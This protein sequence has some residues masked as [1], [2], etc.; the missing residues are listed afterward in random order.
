ML[1]KDKVEFGSSWIY[2]LIFAF[3]LIVYSVLI[4]TPYAFLDSYVS[5][6]EGIRHK[7]GTSELFHQI[8]L[9]GRLLYA[10]F[11]GVAFNI[12]GEIKALAYLRALAVIGIG[13]I[14]ALV[15]RSLSSTSIPHPVA[16]V[17]ALLFGLM[18]SYQVYA[19]WAVCF[20]FPWAS[21]LAA[22][23]FNYCDE[24]DNGR[25]R[26]AH[27]CASIL[28]LSASMEIYQP[29]AM[30]F[31]VFAAIAWLLR[32]NLPT[33]RSIFTAGG[34]MALS[35][36]LNYVL[37]KLVPLV[38][39]GSAN[40]YERAALVHNYSEK[41][42]WFLREPLANVLNML[43]IAPSTKGAGVII[44]LIVG[45]FFLFYRRNVR[46]T[47]ARLAI[48]ICLIPLSYAPNL[49][50]G[51]NWASYRTRVALGGLV[52]IYMIIAAMGWGE[53]LK[54][55]RWMPALCVVA[56]T[57][58]SLTAIRNVTLGFAIPQN[59]E[60]RMV[61][62]ALLRIQFHEDDKI[63]I[64]PSRWQQTFSPV[65]R[66]DEFGLPSTS[67]SYVVPSMV[68]LILNEHRSPCAGLFAPA[69]WPALLKAPLLPSYKKV[70]LEDILRH[71]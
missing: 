57:L 43:S 33:V 56:V 25:V 34:V 2:P 6:A 63:Y 30:V 53:L 47:S 67:V 29:A 70:D 24:I 66:Y 19:A 58:G 18:P 41:V 8:L 14:S 61:E 69:D 45:G 12:I 21:A 27:L 44:A 26:W 49:I 54:I 46:E 39:W 23:A 38:W 60:Y 15:Y 9:G 37:L 22:M 64:K 3:F 36:A 59:V 62:N 11:Y 32:K 10:G 7:L 42:I 48:A 16:L 20:P 40:R 71:R 35:M 4:V 52:L 28:L 55:R 50:V 51:E 65:V 17:G 1:K 31:W 68:W 5:L 13:A